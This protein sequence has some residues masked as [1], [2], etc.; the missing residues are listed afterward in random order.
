MSYIQKPS[1]IHPTLR[2]NKVGLTV[3]DYEGSMST[4]CAGCGHDS[5]TAALVLYFNA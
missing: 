2:R 5:V 1:V 4:L 3:R